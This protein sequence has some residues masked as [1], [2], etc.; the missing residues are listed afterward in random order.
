MTNPAGYSISSV[1]AQSWETYVE[2]GRKTGEIH[3]LV[4]AEE[5]Q[6]AGLWR[7]DPAEG[8]EIP[9][10]PAATD[11]FHVIEGEAELETPDGEKIELVAGGIYSFPVGFTATWRTRSPFMK[12]FV[13]G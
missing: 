9:Y 13:A 1:T 4:Q 8:A 5:G 7:I 12:F 6:L 10:K 11:T 2:D 3:W